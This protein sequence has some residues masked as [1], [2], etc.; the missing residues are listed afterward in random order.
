M[1]NAHGKVIDFILSTALP[2][3]SP[4]ENNTNN[5]EEE[6]E[7]E[8]EVEE[9][10]EEEGLYVIRHTVLPQQ[11]DDGSLASDHAPVFAQFVFASPR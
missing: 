3:P 9:E 1:D 8:E 4:Q 6:E 2:F 11:W 10:E 7:E 5:N